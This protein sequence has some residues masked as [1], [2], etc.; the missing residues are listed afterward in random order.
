MLAS[1]VSNYK[2]IAIK[3]LLLLICFLFSQFVSV[4]ISYSYSDFD[5]NNHLA[6]ITHNYDP[7][8]GSYSSSPSSPDSV[9]TDHTGSYGNGDYDAG[10]GNDQT[11]QGTIDN[12]DQGGI[13]N[14]TPDHFDPSPNEPRRH[15][16]D[17]DHGTFTP[18]HAYNGELRIGDKVE[19]ISLIKVSATPESRS[20]S[21]GVQ[22]AGA[23]GVI[24]EGPYMGGIIPWFK[25]DYESGIDG[26]STA[27]SFRL[28]ATSTVSQT[29]SNT[30]CSSRIFKFGMEVETTA[31]LKIRA[32]I[33]LLGTFLGVQKKG[34]RGVIIDGPIIADGYYWYKVDYENG[35]DGWNASCWLLS[36]GY[37]LS[38]VSYVTRTTT[39][40]HELDGGVYTYTI[41]LTNDKSYRVS[42]YD[43]EQFASREAKFRATGYTGDVKKLMA[44]ATAVETKPT[45]RFDNLTVNSRTVAVKAVFG[46]NG[47]HTVNGPITIGHVNWG[48]SST[49][50]T[51]SALANK[52]QITVNL[53][54]TYK[55]PGTYTIKLTG[56]D[57]KTVSKKV[58]VKPI[59]PIAGVPVCNS[60][61]A[62]PKVIVSGATST[63]TWITTNAT[64]ATIRQANLNQALQVSP[65]RSMLV[66]PNKTSRFILT[67]TNAKGVSHCEAT[68]QVNTVKPTPRFDNLTVNSRTV[69]V[70]AVF[71]INGK[72]TV[73]GPITIGH[74]N[75][76][77][78]STNETVS[79]L[80][81]KDQI[82]VNLKHTYKNPGT[83]TIKLTGLDGKTVSKKVVVKP[84]TP[85]AGVPVCNSITANP[86]VIVS[87]A[88]STLTWIT[89]NATKATIRQANLN[90]AL[91]VSPN[92]S[93]L[94]NPNKTSRFIL[95]LTNAKGVSH[96]E[97]TVQ[98][99]S[100]AV[101]GASTDIYDEIGNI[102]L[103]I[104]SLLDELKN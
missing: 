80:A 65:N 57:G 67:L 32:G 75:W 101:L 1:I 28:V 54:H 92:R 43:R 47:K 88:T 41:V 89:T 36:K 83:Y 102:L 58:V 90:Q 5:T 85:I 104:S 87:G 82:T 81:N 34:S 91:Q 97:A 24:I 49:N 74:V 98:V 2:N 84:I 33:S 70:K 62:N 7:V 51:V 14:A 93:M 6:F 52:D 53:K 31:N 4:G 44:M 17:N 50:E 11:S 71:G 56:L 59:T 95:T 86:K 9:G 69:A 76:G 68:V 55:N 61:T 25:V 79:A 35:K 13:T 16:N 8:S 99:N 29:Y 64:K 78:S 10:Y 39:G 3:L 46:I 30:A 38:D 77:D 42:V 18:A 22:K 37:S 15:E 103:K 73:N 72:H 96:C 23:A 60:I 48:D 27:V 19:T 45:P 63:L 21:F 12:N 20:Y 100:G 40:N 66:N 94:V 26:W